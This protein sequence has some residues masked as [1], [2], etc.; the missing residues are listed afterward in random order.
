MNKSR[1]KIKKNNKSLNL[2]KNKDILK[3]AKSNKEDYN[4][5]CYSNFEEINDKDRQ[6]NEDNEDLIGE[7]GILDQNQNNSTDFKE[8]SKQNK[9]TDFTDNKKNYS[10][11]N[12]KKRKN[13]TFI[14]RK[15]KR[16]FLTIKNSKEN[17]TS[18]NEN[19]NKFRENNKEFTKNIPSTIKS[20]ID[21]KNPFEQNEK[22][23][24]KKL[25]NKKIKDKELVEKNKINIFNTKSENKQEKKCISNSIEIENES[26]K[27]F[28]IGNSI[29]FRDKIGIFSSRKNE[30]E[31]AHSQNM[32]NNINQNNEKNNRSF[33]SLEQDKKENILNNNIIESRL[34]P[35]ENQLNENFSQKEKEQQINIIINLLESNDEV[36]QHQSS[37]GSNGAYI[38]NN[39]Y[40]W[41]LDD[42]QQNFNDF[43]E[44]V[45]NNELLNDLNEDNDDNNLRKEIFPNIQCN[46][47]GIFWK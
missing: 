31:D 25:E 6:S 32:K 16:K 1:R 13:N 15:R 40:A 28:N 33:S 47:V 34:L 5:T 14:K 41:D 22:H 17:K 12:N 24:K 39:D 19:K 46:Q 20:T 3:E 4:D 36:A 43:E 42:N 30:N 44:D 8:K 10:D 23:I 37:E 9:S 18:F 11:N 7:M 38:Q 35:K 27:V 45:I 29:K 2:Y 26:N 21:S